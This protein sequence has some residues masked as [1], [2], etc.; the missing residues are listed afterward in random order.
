MG[1]WGGLPPA[2]VSLR[3]CAEAD[4]RSMGE[5]AQWKQTCLDNTAQQ[6]QMQGACRFLLQAVIPLLLVCRS[7]AQESQSRTQN[8]GFKAETIVTSTP[9]KH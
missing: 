8:R 3:D 7:L 9:L 6:R 2:P 1:R 5:T 4:S